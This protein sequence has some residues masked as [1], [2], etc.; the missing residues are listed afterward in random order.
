MENKSSQ[1]KL[2]IIQLTGG[3]DGLNTVIPIENDIYY[4]ARPHLSISKQESLKLTDQLSFHTAL[5]Y[6][7]R[8]YFDGTLSI[9]NNVG[10][11]NASRS[12]FH[13]MDVWQTALLSAHK[14]NTG[15]IGRYLDENAHLFQHNMGAI[16]VGNILSTVMRGHQQKGVGIDNFVDL[17]NHLKGEHYQSLI[18]RLP[19]IKTLSNDNLH[20]IYELLV[21]SVDGLDDMYHRFTRRK[22]KTPVA[23]NVFS[24]SLKMVTDLIISEVETQIFY[25]SHGSF[26]THVSQL[27]VQSKLLQI[28]NKGIQECIDALTTHDKMKD[29]SI[30]IFSEFGRRLQENNGKGTDHGAANN[31]YIISKH[32]KKPGIYNKLDSLDSLVEGDVPFEIDFR[33]IYANILEDWLNTHSRLILNESVDKID[34]FSHSAG[35]T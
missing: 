31:L 21:D 14:H 22:L 5:P 15:W 32:L 33:R 8:L 17:H 7:Q 9:V 20:H 6:F 12:H 23:K 28:L 11:P 18:K 19:Q 34:I 26:D 35:L 10:Y 29:V 30:L 13:S 27:P 16:E 24:R 4:N 1:K 25:V 3:N 2:I